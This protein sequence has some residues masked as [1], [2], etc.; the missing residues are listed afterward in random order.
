MQRAGTERVII[1]AIPM[2]VFSLQADSSYSAKDYF[3]SNGGYPLYVSQIS[4]KNS[5]CFMRL[6]IDML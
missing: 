5:E 6:P 3:W 2:D 1:V 4:L